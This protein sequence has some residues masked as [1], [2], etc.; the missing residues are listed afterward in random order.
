VSTVSSGHLLKTLEGHTDAVITYN[1][2]PCGQFVVSGSDD[3]TIKIW[4][5]N[6][7]KLVKFAGKTF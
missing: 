7:E 1:F 3:H 5:V 6:E 2:S 4:K